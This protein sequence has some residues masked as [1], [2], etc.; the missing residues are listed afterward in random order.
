[1]VVDLVCVSLVV[2]YCLS[3]FSPAFEFD[4]LSTR[5]LAKRLTYLVRS[6]KLNLNSISQFI[7]QSICCCSILLVYFSKTSKHFE[8][9]LQYTTV[10]SVM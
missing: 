4:L 8:N 6:G 7:N 1:M 3:V 10:R 9:I 5:V 2:L